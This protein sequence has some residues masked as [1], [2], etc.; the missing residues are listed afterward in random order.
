MLRVCIR[1]TSCNGRRLNRLRGSAAAAVCRAGKSHRMGRNVVVH[2]LL[3]RMQVLML[4]GRHESV[5]GTVQC[6][7]H[8]VSRTHTANAHN[9]AGGGSAIDLNVFQAV[10]ETRERLTQAVL[11]DVQ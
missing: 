6:K 5:R 10:L 1:V 9:C 8:R 7:H 4:I 11:F 3:M 2:I